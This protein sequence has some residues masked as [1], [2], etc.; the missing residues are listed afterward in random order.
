[1]TSNYLNTKALEPGDSVLYSQ[2][3][4]PASSTTLAIAVFLF[5]GFPFYMWV[6]VVCA[7]ALISGLWSKIA[8]E[9]YAPCTVLAVEFLSAVVLA[10]L[11][12]R[13][14]KLKGTG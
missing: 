5:I 11:W 14:S 12:K 7:G 10:V 13:Y 9:L 8:C 1:M 2:A 6:L 4:V 3:A